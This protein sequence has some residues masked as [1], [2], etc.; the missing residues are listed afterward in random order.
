MD[1][2]VADPRAP[3]GERPDL[4]SLFRAVAA[5]SDATLPGAVAAH[6]DTRQWLRYAAIDGLVGQSD[7]YAFSLNGSHNYYLAG[8]TSGV[9]RVLPWSADSTLSDVMTVVDLSAPAPGTLLTRCAR[10][11]ACWADFRGETRDVLATYETLGLVD[12]AKQW[13]DQIDALVRSD[14]KREKSVEY[15]EARTAQLYDW[16]ASRPRIVRAQLGL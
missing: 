6:L 11:V 7:G 15:Y 5:A 9:F 2:D 13:H 8:D 4:T 1:I 16:L 14:P 10:S 12:L 3:A